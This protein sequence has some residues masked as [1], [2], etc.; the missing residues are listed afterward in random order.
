M[1]RKQG[2]RWIVRGSV[3]GV[4]FRFFVQHEASRLGLTGWARNLDD[5][6]VEVYAA[7]PPARLSDLASALHAGPRMADVRGVEERDEPVQELSG[8]SVR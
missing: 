6:T 4:G 7:G 3:Q 8:F 2:K 1:E 5:G